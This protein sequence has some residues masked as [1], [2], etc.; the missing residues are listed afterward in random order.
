[1]DMYAMDEL[2]VSAIDK[3]FKYTLQPGMSISLRV[4]E[5]YSHFVS[6]LRV[7]GSCPGDTLVDC[8]AELTSMPI[9]YHNKVTTT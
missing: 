3:A 7:G 6:E 2:A 5:H 4:S 8:S 9:S 1:M